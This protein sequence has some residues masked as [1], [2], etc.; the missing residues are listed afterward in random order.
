MTIRPWMQQSQGQQRL[1]IAEP[2]PTPKQEVDTEKRFAGDWNKDDE[3]A[4]TQPGIGTTIIKHSP[5][6]EM[7]KVYTPYSYKPTP[8][9]TSNK[10]FVYGTCMT[11]FSLNKVVARDG[12]IS[13][14][15]TTAV[16]RMI[17]MYD[18]YPTILTGGHTRIIGQLYY[19]TRRTLEFLDSVMDCPSLHHRDII[20]LE[21]GTRAHA[22]IIN[23][24]KTPL[25][26]E[27]ILSGDWIEWKKNSRTREKERKEKFKAL[28]A[29][30]KAEAKARQQAMA[31]DVMTTANDTKLTSVVK[32]WDPIRGE[33]TYS[34]NTSESKVSPN[35]SDK[36]ISSVRNVHISDIP[37]SD[38]K[39]KLINDGINPE[40]LEE[41]AIRIACMSRY[42]LWYQIED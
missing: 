16:Y 12:Y 40:D 6:Q 1:R 9:E 30:G 27:E 21:D 5:Q 33:F 2:S 28:M 26:E 10:I 38:L 15:T 41:H 19:T 34:L 32:R 37:L 24:W 36:S 31:D 8:S 35:V 39:I 18:E 14:A 29:R 25:R 22:Y 23:R 13:P 11:G 4:D 3:N 17:N 20:S 7:S 42:G